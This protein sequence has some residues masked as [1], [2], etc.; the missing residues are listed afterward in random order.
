M[1]KIEKIKEGLSPEFKLLLLLARK[2][3]ALAKGDFLKSSTITQAIQ[4]IRDWENFIYLVNQ[5]RVYPLVYQAVTK[6]K[7]Q[8]PLWVVEKLKAMSGK[9]RMDALRQTG[10]MAF[11]ANLFAQ[12]EIPVIFVKSPHLA[13]WIY[14]DIAL[15]PSH[16]LDLYV[17][18]GDLK[19]AIA[20]LQKE[21]YYPLHGIG[22]RMA[23]KEKDTLKK[24]HHICFYHQIKKVQVELHWRLTFWQLRE[25]FSFQEMLANSREKQVAG[26]SVT[27]LSPEDQF[28]FLVYHGCKHAWFRLR[29]LADIAELLKQEKEI[30]WQSVVQKI[31]EKKLEK[32]LGQGLVLCSALFDVALERWP[33]EIQNFSQDIFDP[34]SQD[35]ALAAMFF[36]QEEEQ[37]L[38]RLR[39]SWHANQYCFAI[40]SGF[41]P[42]MNFCFKK[43]GRIPV[44][45]FKEIVF[46][47]WK[48]EL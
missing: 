14:G 18:Q 46:C 42:K 44:K 28:V 6:L 45:L 21:G 16:D 48:K 39:Q 22:E 24:I 26:I 25:A 13:Q 29:W 33:R 3:V 37:K 27:I 47:L 17:D 12:A 20:L 7:E 19:K 23:V 38:S 2:E 40:L 35:L 9:N 36:I 8:I 15:R 1:L 31:K 4:Q 34:A 30:N 11:L 5:H 10:E 41:S 43:M 32:M